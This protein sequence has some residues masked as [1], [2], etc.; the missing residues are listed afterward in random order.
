MVDVERF[1]CGRAR[2]DGVEIDGHRWY[3]RVCSWFGQERACVRVDVTGLV[4]PEVKREA[5]RIAD[6]RCY[7]DEE[8][9]EAYW[10]SFLEEAEERL[11]ES[12]LPEIIARDFERTL[13]EQ[14]CAD[15]VSLLARG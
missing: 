8:C 9:I 14:A 12:K 11:A 4:E 13:I 10:D 3:A 6:E 15:L 7:G 1:I 5:E 2:V